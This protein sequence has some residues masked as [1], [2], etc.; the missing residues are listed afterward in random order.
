MSKGRKDTWHLIYMRLQ[1]GELL[2]LSYFGVITFG[3]ILLW[4]PW[5]STNGDLPF[6]DALFTSTSAV[7]VTGLSTI[8]IG[9][10]LTLFGKVVLLGLIQTGGLGIM[11]FTVLMFLTVGR[12]PALRDRWVIENMFSTNPGARIWDFVKAVFLFTFVCEGAGVLLLTAA[13]VEY[14]FS[15]GKALWYALFHSVSAFCNAGFSFFRNNLED[16][17]GDFLVSLTIC[18][19]IIVGGIGFAVMYELFNYIRTSKRHRISLSTRL[20]LL[21]TFFLLLSGT[22]LIYFF[23]MNNTIRQIPLD[24]Q[25]LASFFQSTT[26][27]TAGFNTMNMPAL[28]NSA[29]LVLIFLMFIGASPGSTGGGVRTTTL[30][31]MVALFIKR[32][33]GNSKVN[34]AGRKI[35]EETMRRA[36][37]LSILAILLVTTNT[38]L[39]LSS[40]PA[41]LID[42]QNRALVINYLFESVS[43]LGTVGLSLGIT[44]SLNVAGKLLIIVLM[45]IGRV[46]LVTVAYG[47]LRERVRT[48]FEYP[49]EDVMI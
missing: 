40:Q 44:S 9:S 27:R 11:T 7:C 41:E 39:L 32:L 12:L 37:S 45:F 26:A 23:E 31:L 43:A 28:S 29:V 16:F 20:V 2:V 19:L 46:G 35:P 14:G 47:L 25:L 17:Q 6:I 34:I 8:D 42:P 5:A 10:K 13:W 4:L 18:G 1:S 36:V 21:T 49:T 3:A 33:R 22:L 24:Q 15:I 30:A 38:M 48:K